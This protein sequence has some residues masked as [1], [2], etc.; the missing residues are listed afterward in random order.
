MTIQRNYLTLQKGALYRRCCHFLLLRSSYKAILPACIT[1][2]ALP[3]VYIN[4]IKLSN[5]SH[6]NLLTLKHT[7]IA[8]TNIK[9]HEYTREDTQSVTAHIYTNVHPLTHT[10]SHTRLCTLA[11]THT[12][13][14]THAGLQARTHTQARPCTLARTHTASLKIISQTGWSMN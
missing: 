8:H 10:L 7:H 13:T 14:H 11:R 1:T 9:T 2:A 5:Y 6:I 12:H 4:Q 3:P